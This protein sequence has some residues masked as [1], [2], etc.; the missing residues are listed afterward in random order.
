MRLLQRQPEDAIRCIDMRI[1][2][3]ARHGNKR[4]ESEAW[5]QKA[6]AYEQM[7]R[8]S[9]ALGALKQSLAVS[10]RP[11]PYESLHRYLEDITNRKPF[12]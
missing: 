3:A 10:Q 11:E 1:D 12:R 9:D 6:R 5:E 8:T 4:M 7:D 2:L